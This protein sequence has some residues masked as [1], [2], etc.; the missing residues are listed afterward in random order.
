MPN[1]GGA[2]VGGWI[3]RGVLASMI[4]LVVPGIGT[5]WCGMQAAIGGIA[6]YLEEEAETDPFA[7]PA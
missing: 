3:R 5:G 7:L 6:R 2:A 4:G 1:W